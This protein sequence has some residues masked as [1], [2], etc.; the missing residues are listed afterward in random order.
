MSLSS[1]PAIVFRRF[2][3]AFRGRNDRRAAWFSSR[4]R[5]LPIGTCPNDFRI[6]HIRSNRTLD[7]FTGTNSAGYF[8]AIDLHCSS[9]DGSL[10][11]KGTSLTPS[12]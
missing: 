2:P 9:G 10:W 3:D 8:N 7:V 5:T 6:E 11:S 12:T 1:M 4:Y